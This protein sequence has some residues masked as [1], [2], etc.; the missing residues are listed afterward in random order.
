MK[1]VFHVTIHYYDDTL[2]EVDV[3]AADDTKA[4]VA[5]LA[6][7]A[8]SYKAEGNKPPKVEYCEVEW[9]CKAINA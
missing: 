1:N 4:R 2:S 8:K 3:I 7:D 5:A 9:I 6:E